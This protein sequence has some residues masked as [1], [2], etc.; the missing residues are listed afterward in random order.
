VLDKQGVVV[1]KR[2]SEKKKKNTMAGDSSVVGFA[3]KATVEVNVPPS[4]LAALLL[5]RD[6]STITRFNPTVVGGRDVEWVH[7]SSS[8]EQ[9]YER[10]TYIE[11]KPVWPL[12]ARDFVCRVRYEKV[13]PNSSSS[14]SS[15]SSFCSSSSPFELIVNSATTHPNAPPLRGLVRGRLRGLHLMEP[16]EAPGNPNSRV[17][18]TDDKVGQQ[19]AAVRCLYTCIHEID[20]AGLAPRRL[21][22][23]FAVRRPRQ[24]CALVKALAE[25]IYADAMAAVADTRNAG[26]DEGRVLDPEAAVARYGPTASLG[27]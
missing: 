5:T 26:Q 21:V 23:W 13:L 1:M 9:I 14:L 20:P 18:T 19:P 2:I 3:V 25:A 10:V 27:R 16:V 15:K 12:K 8:S 11:T 17:A 6:Y 22:N 4:W 24:Y 7:T